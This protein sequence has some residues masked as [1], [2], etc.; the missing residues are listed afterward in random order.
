MGRLPSLKAYG[1]PRQIGYLIFYVTNRCNFRCKF[2]FYYAEI[3]K[4]RKP[5]ELTLAEIERFAARIGPLLQL[6]LT[7]GEPFL[8][9][10]FDEIYRIFVRHTGVRYTTIPTNASLTDRMVRFLE[11]VLPATPDSHLRLT[12]SID[13]I[14]GEHDEQRSMSG[15]FAKIRESYA[16]I[17]PLRQRFGNLVLD[18]NS[19]FTAKSEDRM[20]DI[21]NFLHREFAFDNLS[22]TYARGNIKDPDL[23][24]AAREKYIAVN[25][26]LES[27]ER[28]KERR[29]LYPLWRGVRD[30]SR[31]NLIDTVFEDRF[32]TPCVAGRKLVVV[33]ETGEL[34][35][36]EILDKSMGN[37]REV[38]FDPYALLARAESK[39]LQDWIVDTKCKCS[40]ECALGA[41]VVWNPSQYPR[42]ALSA[43]R[44]IGQA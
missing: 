15:S 2:C 6:S 27:F 35:P 37:L 4:G 12:F 7:G 29:L 26:L 9:K 40:F 38:D 30:I 18:A 3:E 28:K 33:S 17:A 41:N 39:A 25:E 22:V 13:G 8:R 20:L 19:V 23:K 5:E 31:R 44:N 34:K 32:V 42:L 36:C 24:T 43:L 16:A 11:A 1:D 14:E 21:L 10:D